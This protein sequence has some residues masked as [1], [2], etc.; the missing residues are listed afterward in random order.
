MNA[1]SL[2]PTVENGGGHI[3]VWGTISALGMEKLGFTGIMDRL[4]YL[5][6]LRNNLSISIERLGMENVGDLQV[7]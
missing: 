6:M 2:I 4:K 3:M 7:G 1:K 5:N